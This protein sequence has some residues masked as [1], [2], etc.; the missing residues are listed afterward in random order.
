MRNIAILIATIFLC[1]LE[2]AQIL[3]QNG[4][5]IKV[6]EAFSLFHINSGDEHTKIGSKYTVRRNGKLIG[7]LIVVRIQG[8]DFICRLDKSSSL[9]MPRLGDDVTTSEK[10]KSQEPTADKASKAKVVTSNPKIEAAKIFTNQIQPLLAKR[11][12]QCH[13]KEKQKDKL[14]LTL[15]NLRGDTRGIRQVMNLKSPSNSKILKRITDREDPMPPKGKMLNLAEIE[16][17]R[18]WITAGAPTT[19]AEAKSQIPNNNISNAQGYSQTHTGVIRISHPDG[20]KKSAIQYLKGRRHGL[21]IYWYSNGNKQSEFNYADDKL[22][23]LGRYWYDDGQL[24]HEATYQRGLL[25]G[26]AKDWWPDGKP[27]SVEQFVNGRKHGR[28]R[29]WWPT[30]KLSEET[31]WQNGTLI[32]KQEWDHQG[33][34]RPTSSINTATSDLDL[35]KSQKK[36]FADQVPWT[37]GGGK[38]P[39]DRIYLG[40]P[41]STIEKVFGKPQVVRTNQWIYRNMKIRDMASGEMLKNVIFIFEIG[42]V[43]EV[44]VR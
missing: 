30:G 15:L 27:C 7:H 22:H 24:Q 35:L 26:I 6:N 29:S 33:N 40:K 3:S 5:V 41:A 18:K 43:N 1:N 9:G 16:A 38:Y 21:A 36:P 31:N 2:A 42:R 39:I 14:N 32:R 23:G 12:Y 8:K 4:K 17:I 20:Q 44:K 13:G 11:C 37:R 34:I 28:W 25:H 19:L 10:K